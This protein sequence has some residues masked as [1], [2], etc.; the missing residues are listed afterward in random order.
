[1]STSPNCPFC[2]IVTGQIPAA[3]VLATDDALAFLDIGPLADGHT[4]LVPKSHYPTLGDM[5][6]DALQ[7]LTGHLPALTGAIMSVTGASGFNLLQNNGSAA[8]QVVDHVHF[9]IIPRT[10]GDGLGFRWNAGSYAPGRADA[11]CQAI[12]AA[13]RH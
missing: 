11:L 8:G 9:H 10:E 3:V 2:R 1:M 5:P 13:L 6:P 7:R 12:Q 4:L